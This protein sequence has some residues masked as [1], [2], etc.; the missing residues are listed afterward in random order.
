MVRSDSHNRGVQT[1]RPANA[2]MQAADSDVGAGA[3]AGG[4]SG[5]SWQAE[6][7]LRMRS[8]AAMPGV[9]RFNAR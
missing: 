3:N 2:T 5:V 4:G 6:Q 7:V 8:A 9:S 1:A